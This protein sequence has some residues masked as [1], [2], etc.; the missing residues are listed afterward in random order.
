MESK[1]LVY[2]DDDPEDM[3]LFCEAVK[4]INPS[5]TCVGARN[6]KEGLRLLSSL[7]PDLIFLDINMPVMDGTETLKSIKVDSRLNKLPVLMLS[8]TSDPRERETFK[9]LGAKA[10]LTKPSTFDGL[11]STLKRYLVGV[12]L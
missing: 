2:I 11:C 12:T 10:C 1:V 4:V 3:E 7:T 5:Y 8:T 6:G 9:K